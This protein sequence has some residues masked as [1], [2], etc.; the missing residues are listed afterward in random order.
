MVD[1]QGGQL[2]ELDSNAK[3]DHETVVYAPEDGIIEWIDTEAIGWALVDLGCGRKNLGD[4]LDNSAGIEFLKKVGEET[5]KGDPVY[6][7]FNSHP[8]RLDSVSSKLEETFRT[9]ESSPD[10]V[11]ILG[12]L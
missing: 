9:G 4:S 5:H 12:D 8:E 11:L 7:V 3:P 2:D 10:S 1:A 6:R